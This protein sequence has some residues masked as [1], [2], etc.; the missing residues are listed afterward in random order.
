MQTRN[1]KR[2]RQTMVKLSILI[3]YYD[4]YELTEKLLKELTIQ[5][6]KDIEIILIDDGCHEE[7]FDKYKDFITIHLEENEG[8]SNAL[9]KGLE[10]ATGKYI[11]FI[12]S[13]DQIT[14]DYVDILIDTL[15]THDEEIIYFNWADYNKNEIVRRPENYALWKAIYK[16][17]IFPRFEENRRKNN[18]R[19]VQKV[20][21][22]Q[23][24]SEYYIDRVLYI[25]N[26]NRI[27][28]ITWNINK[29]EKMI[30]VEVTKEFTLGRFDE[31]KDTI[32][33]K[34]LDTYGKLYVGDT[35][36]CKRELYDY[37]TGN[38]EFQTVVVKMIELIPEPTKEELLIYEDFCFKGL[39]NI[40]KLFSFSI[41]FL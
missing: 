8:M 16:R 35:F 20:L 37:L 31:I 9:N 10:Y 26:S 32:E 36:K 21:R 30:K 6:T 4:T 19:P 13:D 2:W 12:D 17:E 14:M 40:I 29:E 33:R 39:L 27:G 3:A 5:K 1:R 34:G 18:D 22:S 11:G 24:H 28:S 25:Y 7:R 38:N 23:S 41:S 15:K